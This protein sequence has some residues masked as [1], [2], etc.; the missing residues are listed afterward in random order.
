[1]LVD[2]HDLPIVIDDE[3]APL[4]GLGEADELLGQAIRTMFTQYFPDPQSFKKGR[5]P[6][7]SK[8]RPNPY[9]PVI[10]WFGKGNDL[11]LLQDESDAAYI[12]HLY[13]VDG[14]YAV[15]KQYYA[16]ATEVQAGLLMEFLLHGLAEFS[17]ISKKG[18]ER[19][20]YAFGDILGSMLNLNLGDDE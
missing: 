13:Q 9:Q 5:D 14:L 2:L 20:G 7:K 8:P 17:L 1:M 4:L 10:D 18:V 19:G 11:A 15:V 6:Q 16:N 12:N 3:H